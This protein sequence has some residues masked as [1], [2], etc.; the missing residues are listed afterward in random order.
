[1]NR[2]DP[3][4]G[5]VPAFGEVSPHGGSP[6]ADAKDAKNFFCHGLPLMRRRMREAMDVSSP[7]LLGP[8][9]FTAFGRFL[10]G[11]SIFANVRP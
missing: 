11:I 2:K 7:R 9:V 4:K 8:C 6:R 3:P 1:M 5:E 10:K